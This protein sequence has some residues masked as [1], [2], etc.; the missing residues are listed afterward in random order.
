MLK[1]LK[2]INNSVVSCVDA[3]G[4]ELVVMGKGLAFRVRPG[5]RL[6]AADVEKVFR[7]DSPEQTHRLKD[8][9]S[10]L[11][12]QLLELCT[13]II[14]HAKT[15]IG[16]RL[17]ESI[18]LTLTDHI[19]FTLSRIREGRYLP[20]PLLTEVRVFYPVEFSVGLYAL[21]LIRSELGV[22]FQEDEAASIAL[23]LVNAEYDGSM[24]ATIRAAQVLPSLVQIMEDWPGLRL[25]RDHLFYNEL[26]VHLKFLAMQA[27][28]QCAQEWG[29]V[30]LAENVQQYFPNEFACAGAMTDC[31]SEKCGCTVPCAER[32]Y[33]ALCIHRACI[34]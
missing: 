26:I 4:T 33:L 24:S 14:E 28:T 13:Q 2:A 32:A 10:Q 34:S 5:D 7:M 8:L 11:P 29:G 27:F 9:F 20:N 18:Y 19:D 6:E 22:V 21:E 25:D 15:T 1:V 12:P 23:H 3:D 30:K 31:L 17:N 16:H